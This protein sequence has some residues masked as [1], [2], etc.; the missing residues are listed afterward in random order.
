[1]IPKIIHYC[2]LSG[3]DVP[4]NLKK[5]MESWN[6]IIPDYKFVKWDFNRFDI[7][8]S[9]WVKEAFENKKY[10]FACDYIRLYAVYN[11]GGIYLD[12][13]MEVLKR[14]DEFLNQQYMLA[15]ERESGGGIEA[16][17]FGA[18]AHSE[19][20]GRCLDYYADRHFIQEDGSFDQLPLP[21]IMQAEINNKGVDEVI[22][23]CDYFT[24]KS[25]DTGIISVTENTHTIHHF[26]G[27][28]KTK[29]EQKAHNIYTHFAGK[30]KNKKGHTL[31]KLF[32]FPYRVIVKLERLGIVG[33]IRFA[34]KKLFGKI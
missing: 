17:C 9:A 10:A 6:K 12:M 31:G 23:S 8:S 15:Y 3:D 7:E 22:Y 34:V 29:N 21:K 14:F 27:S 19:Y 4:E 11:Y 1:M 5:C 18:E 20:I 25:Y 28:W 2:W 32:S 24:A 30:Y 13:D 16:G 33:T 26:A